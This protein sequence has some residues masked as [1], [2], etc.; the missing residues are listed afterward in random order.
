MALE[1]WKAA[2]EAIMAA[3]PNVLPSAGLVG[4]YWPFR[5][6]PDC[7]PFIRSIFEAG[8]QVALP[9]VA[10]RGQPLLFRVWDETTKMQSGPWNILEP[11]EGAPVVPSALVVPLVGFD[12]EGFRLGY[13]AGYYDA[14]LAALMPRPFTV[15]VGFEFSLLETIFPQPHDAP[16]D[17]IVTEARVR[18]YRET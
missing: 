10:G 8:G 18:T 12:G 14:T 15:G 13:G 9:V 3:V 4:C 17:V 1:V 7:M 2:G 11:A 6:E 16:L 5:R